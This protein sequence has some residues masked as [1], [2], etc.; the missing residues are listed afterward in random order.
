MAHRGV[1]HVVVWEGPVQVAACGYRCALTGP[2]V[3]E[4]GPGAGLR[5]IR[6]SRRVTG[7][8]SHDCRPRGLPAARERGSDLHPD[9]S[10]EH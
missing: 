8:L 1:D 5:L 10:V 3:G 7:T 9:P 6:S 2:R 4:R